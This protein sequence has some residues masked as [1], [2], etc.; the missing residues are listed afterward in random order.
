MY[1]PFKMVMSIKKAEVHPVIG[2]IIK[3]N[4]DCFDKE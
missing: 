3:S 2:I 1:V 4:L